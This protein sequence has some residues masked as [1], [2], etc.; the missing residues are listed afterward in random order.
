MVARSAGLLLYRVTAQG[1]VEVLLAHPGGPFWSGKDAGVWSIPKG[2]YAPD[3]D[4]LAT[5]R[6][7]FREEVGLEPPPGEPLSL[8]ERRQPSGKWVRVWAV[9]GDLDVT[10]ASSNTF[11]IEWPK[12]SGTRR[13]FPEVDRVEWMS[14]ALARHKLLKGQV[15]F[16]DAL[17]EQLGEVR[18]VTEG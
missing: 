1:V 16:L 12:G 8:G 15:S 2:E 3:D 10:G 4:A 6:R 7:E 5:A 13:E 14:V 17:V 18:A 9:A 11:E